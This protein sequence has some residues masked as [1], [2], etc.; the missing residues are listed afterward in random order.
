MYA[1][2]MMRKPQHKMTKQYNNQV[3]NQKTTHP[4]KFLHSNESAVWSSTATR[5]QMVVN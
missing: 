4:E 3:G 2:Q 1:A 5:S